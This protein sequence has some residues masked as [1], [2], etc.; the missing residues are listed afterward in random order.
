VIPNTVKKIF[1]LLLLCL[2][3]HN[4]WASAHQQPSEA[5]EY[6]TI[7][8][9]AKD[10]SHTLPL[11]LSCLEKQTWPANKTYLYIRT[12][13][14]RD[15][16]KEI[17]KQWVDKVRDKY[18]GVFFDDSDVA[19]RVEKYGQHEWNHIRFKVLGKIRQDSVDWAKKQNSHYFVVDCDNFIQPHTLQK[20]VETNLPV[21]APFLRTDEFG[22][23]AG[24]SNY[25]TE[26]DANGYLMPA[27]LYYEILNRNIRGLLEQPVVH[28]AYFIQKD[29]LDKIS[30][31]DNS[32]RYEYVIFSDVL[33]KQSIPQYLDNRE[34]YG[35]IT[36]A[37][38]PEE[39][40]EEHWL[41]EFGSTNNAES[42]FTKMYYADKFCGEGSTAQN[43]R[44][45]RAFLKKFLK[46]HNIHSVVDLGCGNWEFSKLINWNGI[47]YTG[48]DIVAALISN[49]K[50]LFSKPSINFVHSNLLDADLPKADLLICK[51]VLQHLPT[52]DVLAISPLLKKYKYCLI[53]NDISP[54]EHLINSN[55][56]AGGYRPLDLTQPPFNLKGEKILTFQSGFVKKQVLLI[57]N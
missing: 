3:F 44:E 9:L 21:V 26:I 20:L 30:Y 14:N 36:F 27:K 11:Y 43:T 35:R 12:N 49:N 19:A 22:N 2:I 52:S 47:D 33:R 18:A 4:N 16:T 32:N 1:A 29:I 48:S 38:N 39:F 24:Y 23:K 13:N 57:S 53:T 41:S 15:D 6:V 50:K 31:D 42:V 34:L 45:Y 8:I 10:K 17:L 28:C 54:N 37:E 5:D 55:V 56:H 51:D 46:D 40:K 7:A 25:H